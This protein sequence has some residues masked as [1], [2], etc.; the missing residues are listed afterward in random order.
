MAFEYKIIPPK[1]YATYEKAVAAAEKLAGNRKLRYFI[2]KLDEETVERS[3]QIAAIKHIG[4]YFPVF[5]GMEAAHEGIHFH[6][7]VV[8]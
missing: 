1:T 7:N 3:G 6:F 8:A 2:Q 4:R 5:I